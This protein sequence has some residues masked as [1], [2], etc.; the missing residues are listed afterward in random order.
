MAV[1]NEYLNNLE[2]GIVDAE[3]DCMVKK[4]LALFFCRVVK[5]STQLW[6]LVVEQS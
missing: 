4:R 5:S 2:Q 1:L 3:I 6:V